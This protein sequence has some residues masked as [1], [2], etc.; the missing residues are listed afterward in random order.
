M[1]I[2]LKICRNIIFRNIL[3][4]ILRFFT[5]KKSCIDSVDSL[6]FCRNLWKRYKLCPIDRGCCIYILIFNGVHI[7]EIMYWL[8]LVSIKCKKSFQA[9]V[10]WRSFFIVRS[11]DG[12]KSYRLQEY[13][14]NPHFWAFRRLDI[15]GWSET[16][17]FSHSL[18]SWVWNHTSEHAHR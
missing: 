11:P 6:L 12:Q 4:W 5:S 15:F 14:F 9:N 18:V 1:R 13:F 7:L 10:T 2:F 8:Y 17:I 16:D 3:F